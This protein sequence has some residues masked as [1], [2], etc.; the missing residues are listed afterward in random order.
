MGGQDA[1]VPSV[2]R[3]C[4]LLLI[5]AGGQDA[6]V[7]G[8]ERFCKLLLIDRR[9]GRMPAYPGAIAYPIRDDGGQ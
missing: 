3:F 7:P 8:V 5:E 1:R 6:R 2:E 9:A 4:K